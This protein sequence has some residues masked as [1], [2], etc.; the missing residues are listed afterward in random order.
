[1]LFLGGQ[2]PIGVKFGDD[3]QYERTFIL[4]GTDFLDATMEFHSPHSF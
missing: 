2:T 3:P 4:S 1:M